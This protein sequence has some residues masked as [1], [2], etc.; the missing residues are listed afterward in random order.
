MGLFSKTPAADSTPFL[1]SLDSF[2]EGGTELVAAAASTTRR[3]SSRLR[4]EERNTYASRRARTAWLGFDNISE[5]RN[6]V[7]RNARVAGHSVL[8]VAKVGADGKP[9]RPATK[10]IPD[11][12]LEFER[13]LVSD[14]GG[15]P[16]LIRRFVEQQKVSAF[17]TLRRIRRDGKTVAFAW[18][19]SDEISW[20]DGTPTLVRSARSSGSTGGRSMSEEKLDPS[21]LVGDVWV[22]HPR[23]ID[24]P[25]SPLFA[26][27]VEI[28]QF[29]TVQQVIS[30]R[31]NDRMMLSG[32]WLFP[33]SFTDVWVDPDQ[34]PESVVNSDGPL[35]KIDWHMRQRSQNG[36]TTPLLGRGSPEDI[37]AIRYLDGQ[38]ELLSG[39]MELQSRLIER[40]LNGFD[41]NKSSVKGREGLNHMSAWAEDADEIRSNI[42]PELTSMCWGL[43]ALALWPSMKALPNDRQID[44]GE[45]LVWYDASLAMSAVNRADNVRKAH[46]LGGASLDAVM[47]EAGLTDDDRMDDEE[48]IR[49]VGKRMKDPYLALWKVPGT[50]EID[51]DKV[52]SIERG[53]ESKTDTS[54]EPNAGPGVGDPGS[55]DDRRGD[56]PRDEQPG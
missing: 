6:A 46:E 31:L 35:A 55:P 1:L 19:S 10:D 24:D 36:V 26:M 23:F 7:Q 47:R 40:M 34:A 22:A 5:I 21:D 2:A 42:L 48:Y 49:W 15:Q 41:A 27:Q 54:S 50:E 11:E 4:A 25:I 30:G 51:W 14:M 32:M 18:H 53:P 16:M 28:E 17:S 45:W 43:T 52:G 9:Y 12:L 3:K 44:P 38:R 37:A 39:D 13:A 20:S 56:T 29:M 8:F 33:S